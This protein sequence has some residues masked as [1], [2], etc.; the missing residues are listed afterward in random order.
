MNVKM[1]EETVARV[2]RETVP[3]VRITLTREEASLLASV[4]ARIG[5]PVGPG[6]PHAVTER[7]FEQFKAVGVFQHLHVAADPPMS[8]TSPGQSLYL[9]RTDLPY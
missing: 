4:L 6:Q 1:G 9:R 8:L 5:G 2:V 7:L 3:V